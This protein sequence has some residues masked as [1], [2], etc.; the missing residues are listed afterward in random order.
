[1]AVD[2]IRDRHFWRGLTELF[3]KFA[4]V[5]FELPVKYRQ[6]WLHLLVG[7]MGRRCSILMF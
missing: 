5:V 7:E 6:T 4:D 2:S 1:M 3:S